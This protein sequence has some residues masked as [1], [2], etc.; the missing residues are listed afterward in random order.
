MKKIYKALLAFCVGL[1][2]VS[3]VFIGIFCIK[4]NLERT[5]ESLIT[6]IRT[7][8]KLSDDEKKVNNYLSK[9]KLEAD[10]LYSSI[11][12]YGIIDWN[13]ASYSQK[14]LDFSRALPKGGDLHVHNDKVISVSDLIDL[15]LQHEEVSIV[16]DE[17]TQYG[18]LYAENE[19][20]NAIPLNEALKDKKITLEQLK[21]IIVL[22]DEDISNGRWVS[23]RKSQTAVN[24]LHLNTEMYRLIYEEGFRNSCKNNACLLEIRLSF[25]ESDQI[26]I[27]NVSIIRDAYYN[28]K[29][30][31]PEL[32]VR[33]I[34]STGK[35]Y[36]SIE[37]IDIEPLRSA[38]RLSKT[39]K[40]EYDSNNVNDF[41]I[42]IDLV[43]QEDARK[44]LEEYR[45]FLSSKEV[46]ESGLKLFLHAGE[47]LRNDNTSV[48][49]AYM[50]DS[51]RVGHA[52]NLYRFPKLMK[53]Y[54]DKKIAIEVCPLSNY[55]LGFV[56]DLR[57][58]PAL[59][60]LQSG[61]PIV[62]SSDD[63]LFFTE[64]PLVNDYYV[65][66]LSWNLDL[67]VIKQLSLNNIIYSGLSDKEIKT[68]KNNWENDWDKFISD[69]LQK[70]EQY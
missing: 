17:G 5:K 36:K 40:D 35:N 66:I 60:Y 53:K 27:A 21:E 13:D 63:G 62:I 45:D 6:S 23:F 15:L 4:N 52:F 65:A 58:H 64:E 67:A 50:L 31:Y 47:S 32:V 33:V 51:T 26:N 10:K 55:R 68:L 39:M 2:C 59:I 22:S 43:G 8:I 25:K 44:P 56:Q 9:I 30:E 57:L 48:I 7:D 16:L 46:Q 70:I 69:M 11:K 3:I 41:I 28:V 38:I 34:A 12:P 1:I 49:D 19:P 24:K 14:L 18:Y 20:E 42:G 54:A 29:E 37:N 61:I